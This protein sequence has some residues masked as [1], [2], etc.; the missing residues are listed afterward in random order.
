MDRIPNMSCTHTNIVVVVVLLF[1]DVVDDCV[2]V[3]FCVGEGVQNV[4]ASCAVWHTIALLRLIV[5][6]A[7]VFGGH[8]FARRY[9]CM[10]I[11]SL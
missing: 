2:V 8:L 4:G 1:F 11:G 3:V 5:A 10:R 9:S 7:A 6:S